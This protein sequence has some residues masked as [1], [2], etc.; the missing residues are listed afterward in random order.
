MQK[1]IHSFVF[2]C[3]IL[4]FMGCPDTPEVESSSYYQD[5]TLPSTEGATSVTLSQVRSGITKIEPTAQWVSLSAASYSSGYPTVNIQYQTNTSSMTRQ[6]LATI[7]VASGDI[8]ILQINQEAYVAQPHEPSGIDDLHNDISTKP[9][10][11]P[12]K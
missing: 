7:H 8:V 10:Y 12:R 6:C 1:I 9:A 3:C 4:C 2:I 11:S 5:V